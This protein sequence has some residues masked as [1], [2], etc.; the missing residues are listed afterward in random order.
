VDENAQKTLLATMFSLRNAEFGRCFAPPPMCPRPAIRAHSVQNSKVLDLLEANGHVIAPAIRLSAVKE[1]EIEL[2]LIG[3]NRASTF[4]G[5]CADHDREL[6]SPIEL[7]AIDPANLEH[8]FLLAYRAVLYEVHASSAAAWQL[9]T[10]YSKRVELGLDPK[11]QPSEAGIWATHRIL[12]AF[13]TFQYKLRFDAAYLNR[14]FSL[15]SHDIISV[16]VCRPSIAASAVFS[17]EH[18]DRGGESVRVCITVLPIAARETVAVLSYLNEDASLARADL[19]P[20]LEVSGARQAFELSRRLLNNCENFVL[21]PEYVASWT[22]RKRRAVTEYFVRTLVHDDLEVDD[23][24][25][26]L[27]EVAA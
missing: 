24:D 5:L 11:D 14:D 18:L 6:F 15:L 17:P 2:G 7:G 19:G 13:E 23:P 12:V 10:G 4:S 21:S 22:D 1:P 25:L 20:L 8:A 3:R 9:Q 26:L 27:L 16:P